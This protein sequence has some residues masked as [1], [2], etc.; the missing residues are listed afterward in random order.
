MRRYGA[1]FVLLACGCADPDEPPNSSLSDAAV[2]EADASLPSETDLLCAPQ[3]PL[4]EAFVTVNDELEFQLEGTVLVPQGI[5]SYPLLQH[6]GNGQHAALN[7]ILAQ[8]SELGRPCSWRGQSL[9]SA[10]TCAPASLSIASCMSTNQT[11]GH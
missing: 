11:R 10:N 5:N 4:G 6:V 8:A 9:G 3:P 2:P 1:L 7:D